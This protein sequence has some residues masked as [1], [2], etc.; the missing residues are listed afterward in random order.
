MQQ[1]IILNTLFSIL[2]LFSLTSIARETAET[3]QEENETEIT[4]DT[5]PQD[6][7]R[8]ALVIGN[9]D[10]EYR[11]LTN[12]VNDA[13]AMKIFLASRNF[14]KIVYA[15]DANLE[16]MEAKI[17]TFIA[18]LKQEKKSVAFV[19]YS[20]H[21]TQ[22]VSRRWRHEE[23]TNYLIPIDNAK[24]KTITKLDKYSISLNELLSELDEVNHGLNIVLMDACR[25]GL[26]A[27]TKCPSLASLP[28]KGVYIAYATASGNTTPDDSHF[29]KSFIENASQPQKLTDIFSHV[30]KSLYNTSQFPTIQNRVMGDY[31]YFTGSA[32]DD[33][34]ALKA[35]LYLAK[36]YENNALVSMYKGDHEKDLMEYRKAWLYALEARKLKMPEGHVAVKQSTLNQLTDLSIDV[37]T[38]EQY[39]T[40]ALLDIGSVIKTIAYSPDGSDSEHLTGQERSTI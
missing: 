12:P 17:K 29:R 3:E 22:E 25:D 37:L 9:K 14:E 10:Y 36:S 39:S 24:L 35:N 23:L 2:F 15:E 20:G 40:P 13:R 4:T 8:F 38:P 11:P 18:L 26:P 21:G 5:S 31:F 30:K 28:A 6:Y 27:F 32:D 7:K 33:P 16:T 34:K 19:Y 1:K